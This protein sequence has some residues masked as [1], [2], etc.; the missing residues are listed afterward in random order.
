M[1]MFTIALLR[2]IWLKDGPKNIVYKV[3]CIGYLQ[4]RSFMVILQKRPFM[5]IFLY[6]LYNTCLDTTL[7]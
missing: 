3:K 2:L 6:N 4:K 1:K 5:V 7:L